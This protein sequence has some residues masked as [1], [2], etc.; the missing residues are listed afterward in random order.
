KRIE[1]VRIVVSGVGAAGTAIIK[2]L[3]ASGAKD[4]LA[5][6]RNGVN[7]RHSDQGNEQRDWLAN[8]TNSEN[9]QGSL[10]EAMVGADVFIGVTAPNLL[11]EDDIKNMN[12]AGI[13]FAM[14]NPDPEVNPDV[15]ASH[16]AVVAT[17]RSDYPN[18]INNVLAFPG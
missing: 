17:G 14:S 4:V 8:N 1:D 15:A 16:A 11:D 9:F 18:Q 2:L 6:G 13:V 3:I 5:A 10:K 7:G 12:S